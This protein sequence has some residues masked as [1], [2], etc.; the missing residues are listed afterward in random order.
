MNSKPY[1]T[2]GHR[3]NKNEYAENSLDGFKSLCLEQ[4]VDGIELDVIMS[5]DNKIIVSHDPFFIDKNDKKVFI[6]ENTL[7]YIRNNQKK[8]DKPLGQASTLPELHEVLSLFKD[9]DK[10]ILLEVKSFPA[11][12]KICS[13]SSQMLREI[14]SLL[15]DF[16]LVNTTY[17]ISF[18]YRVI[19]YSKKESLQIKTGLILARNLIPITT[20]L[21]TLKPQILVMQKDW[22]TEEQV[23]EAKQCD[24]EVFSWTP[25]EL[26]DWQRLLQIGVTGLIT[27]KPLILSRLNLKKS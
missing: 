17:I 13:H 7:E 2:I 26:V 21:N 18:D 20:V 3:G 22:I 4:D 14:H 27:D 11:I 9:S 6:Y 15:L 23:E 5:S 1:K 8:E 16:G 10:L 12:T 24:V 19:E 25:N